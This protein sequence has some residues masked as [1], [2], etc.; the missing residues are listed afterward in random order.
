MI[1][2]GIR[3]ITNK[4]GELLY[5][6]DDVRNLL[7]PKNIL[8]VADCLLKTKHKVYTLPGPNGAHQNLFITQAGL[9]EV[10][11]CVGAAEAKALRYLITHGIDAFPAGNGKA[12]FRA[13]D[14]AIC[15]GYTN[16]G[17]VIRKYCRSTATGYIGLSGI[18]ALAAHSKLSN[19]ERIKAWLARFARY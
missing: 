15:F 1:G 10:L 5:C 13:R 16:P 3:N 11:S 2:N 14:I 19:A 8:D 9:N 17:K 18:Y 4:Q 7:N 6:L 12:V